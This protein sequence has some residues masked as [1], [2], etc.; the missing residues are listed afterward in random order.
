MGEENVTFAGAEYIITFVAA[1]V[2]IAIAAV[3]AV[4]RWIA[5]A[6]KEVLLIVD[7]IEGQLKAKIER[8]ASTREIKLTGVQERLDRAFENKG[9]GK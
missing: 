3:L 9:N 4:Q 2:F 8:E 5:I 1:T 6:K 7:K